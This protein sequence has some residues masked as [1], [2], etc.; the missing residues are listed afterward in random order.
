MNAP[1]KVELP[2]LC[3]GSV[4]SIRSVQSC[5]K[6]VV[7]WR[8]SPLRVGWVK[9]REAGGWFS[10]QFS[11]CR[12]VEELS[13]KFS[14]GVLTCGQRRDHGSWRISTVRSRWQETASEECNRLRALVCMCQWSMKCASEWCIQ[15][16]SKTNK[17]VYTPFIVTHTKFF[18][19]LLIS[20][21]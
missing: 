6:Q 7:D 20:I 16:I 10:W 13:W 11:W 3:K 14:C 5:Y 12:S 18:F 8:S 17:T 2:S 4:F 15:V 9:W 1:A 21:L 19:L